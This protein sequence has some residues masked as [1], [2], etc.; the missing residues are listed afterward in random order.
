MKHLALKFALKFKELSIELAI[1]YDPH[2]PGSIEKAG[3][4]LRFLIGQIYLGRKSTELERLRDKVQAGELLTRE[5]RDFL[6]AQ[7][8]GNPPSWP[9]LP[10]NRNSLN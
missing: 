9:S 6:H 1:D 10:Q 3:E 2:V 5:E 8:V 4:Q 7:I